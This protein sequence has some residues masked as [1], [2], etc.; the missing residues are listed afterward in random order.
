MLGVAHIDGV[1]H[2]DVGAEAVRPAVGD[3]GVGRAHTPIHLHNET[4][5][6]YI[7]RYIL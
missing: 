7:T 6:L 2:V 5:K 1:V 3:N 4:Q